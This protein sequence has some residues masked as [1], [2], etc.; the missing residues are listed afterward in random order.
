L[1]KKLNFLK[2]DIKKDYY[3]DEQGKED[4]IILEKKLG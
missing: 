2:V 4:A 3:C 1:Y